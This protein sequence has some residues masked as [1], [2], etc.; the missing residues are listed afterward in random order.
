MALRTRATSLSQ[1]ASHFSFHILSDYE[2]KQTS[3][4]NLRLGWNNTS[5]FWHVTTFFVLEEL[6][7]LANCLRSEL[8]CDITSASW[9]VKSC[10][11]TRQTIGPF[12]GFLLLQEDL[13]TCGWLFIGKLTREIPK[14]RT[15][16]LLF[17]LYVFT[18]FRFTNN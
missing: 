7:L 12:L 8:S 16:W 4:G 11:V 2:N 6:R 3:I 15:F 1:S 10:H 5:L 17:L 13:S 14:H 9:S 18:Y